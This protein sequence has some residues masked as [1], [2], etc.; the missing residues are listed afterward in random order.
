MEN[1]PNEVI[2]K[3][4]ENCDGL[5][6]NSLTRTNSEINDALNCYPSQVIEYVKRIGPLDLS[7]NL[8]SLIDPADLITYSME[9]ELDLSRLGKFRGKLTKQIW[10][11][12]IKLVFKLGSFEV[13]VIT[14][15][16]TTCEHLFDPDRVYNKISKKTGKSKVFSLNNMI[17]NRTPKSKETYF[18]G[19]YLKNKKEKYSTI[20]HK[21][22]WIGSYTET[23]LRFKPE[24]Y[25]QILTDL[26]MVYIQYNQYLKYELNVYLNG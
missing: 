16:I 2:A 3:I 19:V 1:L 17:F 21:T 12:P 14:I 23:T 11:Y 7:K 24:I 8:L 9:C 4:G 26:Q 25:D 10:E 6:F 15:D 13:K 22:E 18:R 20:T 5:T